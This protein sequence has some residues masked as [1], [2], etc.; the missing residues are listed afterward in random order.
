MITGSLGMLPSASLGSKHALYEPVHGTAPE[1]VGKNE[2]N[3]SSDDSI[4]SDD[5]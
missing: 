1:I 3:P 4:C 5:A 2:S